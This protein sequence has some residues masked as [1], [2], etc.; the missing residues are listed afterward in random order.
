LRERGHAGAPGRRLFG[1][2]F[3][4]ARRGL[5]FLE[6]QLQLI[7]QPRR[8]LRTRAEAL[9]VQLQDL[10]LQMRDQGPVGGACGPLGRQFSLDVSGP[11]QGA[12][13][14]HLERLDRLGPGSRSS[15][16]ARNRII[17]SAS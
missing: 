8:P 9:T 2:Q 15:V 12:A 5:Q 17:K 1:G 13:Q 7:E 14:R 6:L 16:H 11:R 10:Q 4:L 3:V